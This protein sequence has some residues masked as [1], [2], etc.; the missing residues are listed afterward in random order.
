MKGQGQKLACCFLVGDLMVAVLSWYAAYWLRFLVDVAPA[1]PDGIPPLDWC[2]HGVPLILL[3]TLASNHIAELY[4][5]HRLRLVRQELLGILKANTIMFL[6]L[7]AVTFYRRDPYN[8]RLA[9]GLFLTINVAGQLLAR[10]VAWWLIH[11]LRGRGFNPSPAVIVGSGR[12]AQRLAQTL[13]RNPWTGLEAIGFVDEI[14]VEGL[15][16][17][18]SIDQLAEIVEQ[19]HVAYVFLALP[20][21]RYDDMQR[22]LERLA[23]V[24]VDVRLVPDVPNL[25][26]MSLSTSDLDGLPIVGLRATP[27]QGLNFVIKRVMDMVF[28]SL[29]LVLLW[30]VFLVIA[31]LI[32]LTSHGPVFYS[33]ERAGLGGEPFQ[34]LKFRTMRVDAETETGPVWAAADDPRR[35]GLGRMLRA[36]SLDELPQLINVL[37]GEMSLVG[38][39]P[40]RPVF[41]NKFRRTVPHYM[42]RHSVKAGITGWAQVHGWRGDTSLRKRLQ[43]DLHYIAHWT[44]WLDLRIMVLTLLRGM[45]S[46]NA[47]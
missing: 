35:T 1:P 10:R 38:P 9:M 25:A 8:S 36:T 12:I 40:E 42:V 21:K 26:G 13:E 16:V 4:L 28:G 45:V 44:P 30:P 7:V 17:L 33:Q 27:H 20:L 5:L 23:D 22:V 24:P 2:S 3:L 31:A 37:R 29:A 39:R 46:R 19:E 34:M 43:Y 14:M 41:I 11:S 32:K 18:G 47:Y 6:L 15:P